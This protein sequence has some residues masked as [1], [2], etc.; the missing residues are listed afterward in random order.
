MCMKGP[1]ASPQRYHLLKEMSSQTSLDFVSPV[2]ELLSYIFLFIVHSS[3][4]DGNWGMRIESAL[5]VTR[6]QPKNASYKDVWYGFERLTVVPIQTKMV[7]EI[8]LSRDEKEWLKVSISLSSNYAL[9][10]VIYCF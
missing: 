5:H 8:M 9:P 3:D 4:N 1:I 6:I 7:K 2:V 10:D